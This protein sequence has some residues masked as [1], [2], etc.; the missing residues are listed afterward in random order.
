MAAKEKYAE[1]TYLEC[2]FGELEYKVIAPQVCCRCGTCEAFCPRIE[3]KNN[4]PA[5]VNYDPLCGLCFAYC[6]RT[7]LD[8]SEMESGLF[9]RTRN[10]NDEPL[11]VFQKAASAQAR[12]RQDKAQDGGVATALLV[13]ALESG[14][15]DCAVVTDRDDEWRTVARVATTADEIKDAAGT[16]YTI[17]NSVFAIKD[18]MESGYQKI[19]FVG[20]PCQIQ[21]LRKVQLLKEPYEFGQK[22]I[23][24][25]VGLFC[26]ENFDYDELMDGLVKGRFAL[27]PK[28]V[29]RF[30]IKKG[31]FR[32]IDK[33]GKAHEVKIEE[34]DAYTFKGCGP[35]FD[36][37]SELADISVGSVGSSDGWSTVLTRTNL[38]ERL[39]AS[40]LAG[41]VVQEKAISEKG[42][43]LAKRLAGNKALRFECKSQEMNLSGIVR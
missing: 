19:G 4:R 11:G 31:M 5:L 8:M 29:S 36:F 3:H 12:E 32:V 17:S 20:T 1:P 14:V 25:L 43:A 7:F 40:A 41:G 18:A 13:H 15:I 28:D 27:N 38:G 16:K 42:L 2:G 33:A 24:L 35:C 39:Y 21:A 9:G 6:P 37:A 26:M 34:T 10:A 23:A 22:R 30:E